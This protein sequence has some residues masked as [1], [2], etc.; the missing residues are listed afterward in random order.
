MIMM[1][2]LYPRA[3]FK[4]NKTGRNNKFVGNIIEVYEYMWHACIDQ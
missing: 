3:G 1:S 4:K 2:G